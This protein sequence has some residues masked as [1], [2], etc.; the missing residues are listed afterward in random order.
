MDDIS[1]LDINI[2]F[3]NLVNN[4]YNS[5]LPFI[6]NIS[7]NKDIQ[8]YFGKIV[9][10][11]IFKMNKCYKVIGIDCYSFY[12]IA[13]EFWFYIFGDNSFCSVPVNNVDNKLIDYVSNM[14]IDIIVNQLE[15]INCNL[16]YGISIHCV[17]HSVSSYCLM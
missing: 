5:E 2:N 12:N 1:I 6:V 15:D 4:D 17:E 10:N 14:I 13:I 7:S 3:D 16:K 9:L 11:G 8:E